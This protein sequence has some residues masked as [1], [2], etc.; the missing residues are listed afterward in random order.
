MVFLYFCTILVPYIRCQDSRCRLISVRF[1][2]RTFDV[3]I[4]LADW[5]TPFPTSPPKK[6]CRCDILLHISLSLFS[7]IFTST[8][9]CKDSQHSDSSEK[10]AAGLREPLHQNLI[11]PAVTVSSWSSSALWTKQSLLQKLPKM[12]VFCHF[13]SLICKRDHQTG[14]LFHAL[15]P[16]LA[17]KAGLRYPIT[18]WAWRRTWGWW[19]GC[20]PPTSQSPGSGSGPGRP[21]SQSAASP[22]GL[23]C[24]WSNRRWK[25][26][27]NW[28]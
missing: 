18:S 24:K 20:R 10:W 11:S 25:V 8:N 14:P 7:V 22:P 23:P 5:S 6:Q 21:G 4:W 17:I 26:N 28:D 2:F 3:K 1:W 27:G 13:I 15:V 19:G 12:T 16:G 9:A